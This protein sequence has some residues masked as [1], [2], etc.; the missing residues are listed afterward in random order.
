MVYVKIFLNE[1]KGNDIYQKY[2][3]SLNEIILQF[4]GIYNDSHWELDERRVMKKRLCG[5]GWVLY[6]DRI[7]ITFGGWTCDGSFNCENIYYLDLENDNDSWKES[8]LK[9]PKPGACNALIRDNKTVHIM[10][11]FSFKD[12]YCIDIAELLPTDL[13][14]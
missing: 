7:I 10:P 5:F 1:N 6:D 12:H 4:L 11:Y 2:V 9:C 14:R 13:I 3:F 8:K